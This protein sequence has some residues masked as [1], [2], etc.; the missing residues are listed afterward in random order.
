MSR[1]IF[2]PKAERSVAVV[3]SRSEATPKGCDR[4]SQVNRHLPHPYGRAEIYRESR[5]L[6]IGH[7]AA[8]K[9]SPS[10]NG[11]E[12]NDLPTVVLS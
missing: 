5:T 7:S 11:G 10:K 3:E 6:S 12:R 1:T 4:M 9:F 8:G 2:P